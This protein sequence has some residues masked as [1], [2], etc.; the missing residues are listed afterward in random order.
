MSAFETVIRVPHPFSFA[1]TVAAARFYSV[2]GTPTETGAYRR[3][4]RVNGALAL[5]EFAPVEGGVTARLLAANG[6]VDAAAFSTR[7]RWIL[8]PELD[9]GP[10][11]ALA[12]TDPEAARLIAP[13]YGLRAF[14]LDSAF[15]AL[16]VT[17]IEQQI[18]LS[19]AQTAERWLIA[20][21]GESLDYEGEAYFAFP[22][23]DVLA[24]LTVADLTPLK[25]TFLR[26]DR[27]LAIARAIT[28]GTLDLESLVS[29]P[30]A[31]YTRVLAL[32][33]VGHWTACWTLIRASGQ[34][35]YFGRADVALR[36]AANWHFAGLPGR[37]DGDPMDAI[38]ARYGDQA[39]LAA[40][41]L[42]M[43]Y[44]LHRMKR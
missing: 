2:L 7:A 11:Y 19:M 25:I 39:G 3:V 43:H 30:D 27:L 22:R 15:E 33:G 1:H 41:Y 32:H 42:D 37:M 16:A 26:M 24:Q 18:A 35:R 6:P 34:F 21:Y 13:L 29:D 44:G 28:E 9:L 4:L 17:I 23:P 14:R 8:F 36:A 31:L 12:E 5:A 40:F 10:L 38:F 20:T